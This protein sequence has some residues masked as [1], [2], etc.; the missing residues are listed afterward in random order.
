MTGI[1]SYF[2]IVWAVWLRHC[3]NERQDE[4]VLNWPSIW[5]LPEVVPLQDAEKSAR[6]RKSVN[7]YTNGHAKKK[8]DRKSVQDLTCWGAIELDG[9]G[10]EVNEYTP[11]IGLSPAVQIY[12]MLHVLLHGCARCG[13]HV[14]GMASC[15]TNVGLATK[16]EITPAKR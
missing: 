1:G 2:Y 9:V 12:N 10:Y 15:N 14:L 11:P 3:L 7:G 6:Y 16:S 4:Y 13:M 8:E 5:S